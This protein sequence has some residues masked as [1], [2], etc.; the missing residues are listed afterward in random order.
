MFSICFPNF[1]VLIFNKTIMRRI[2]FTLFSLWLMLSFACTRE[3]VDPLAGNVAD[4]EIEILLSHDSSQQTKGAS[5]FAVP[6]IGSLK[7][8]IFKIADAGHVRLYKDTYAN[9]LGKKIPL[10][11][12]DYKLLA[13]YGDSLGTGFD[14]AYF[15]GI[16]DFTLAPQESEV[17]ETVVKVSNVRVSVEYGENLIYDYP[18]FYSVVKSLTKSG[19]KRSLKFYQDETRAGFVPL[20]QVTLELY[21]RVDGEWKYF[22]SEPVDAKPGDDINFAVET[23]RLESEAGFNVTVQQLDEQDPG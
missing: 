23:K 17:I 21:A 16:T 2:R 22:C 3:V 18:E 12:A 4:G 14:K 15:S 11:C 8:E 6:E 7:V 13:S 10:N 19:K 9:T 20:G 1:A 5:E